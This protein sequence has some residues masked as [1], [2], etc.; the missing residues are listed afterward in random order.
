[1]AG[2]D[3]DCIAC[4]TAL[5]DDGR[6]MTCAECGLSYHLGQ[7]CSGIAS[8]TFTTMGQA[9]RDT[10]ACKT[11]RAN[12]KRVGS[13]SRADPALASEATNEDNPLLL[14]IMKRVDSLPQLL[15]KVDSLLSMKTDVVKLTETVQELEKAVTVLTKDYNE[16]IKDLKESQETVKANEAELCALKAIVQKQ[17]FELERI[18]EEQNA[19]DQY[20]RNA[21]L[22]IHGLPTQPNEN[23]QDVLNDLAEKLELSNFSPAD[24]TAVHRI[25]SKRGRIPTVLV[26]FKS[27]ATKERWSNVRKKL[28]ALHDSGMLPKLFFNDNLTKMNREL[29]WC[30]R[31]TAKAKGYKFAWVKAG[32]IY[33]KKDETAALIRVN[34]QADIDKLV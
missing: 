15:E 1:M 11:C 24:V 5:P 6:F 10:W 13:Q 3:D 9:K 22:E 8:N 14:E 32:K 33:V 12:K 19:A 29:F 26:R 18:R 17:A 4:H 23:L 25:P 28:R 31:T 16:V 34:R 30:A 27:V 7:T 21:N 2:H 20:S